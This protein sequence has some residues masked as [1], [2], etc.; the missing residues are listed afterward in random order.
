MTGNEDTVIGSVEV[1]NIPL[2]LADIAVS[3]LF[4]VALCKWLGRVF[5][6][7]WTGAHSLVYYF[8][9]THWYITSSAVLRQ[10]L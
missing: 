2:F 1:S 5:M 4:L 6:V 9:P 7:S 3:T 8:L 10:R